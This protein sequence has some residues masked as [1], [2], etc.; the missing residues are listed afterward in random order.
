MPVNLAIALS[1][2]DISSLLLVTLWFITSWYSCQVYTA[3]A[4][5][6]SV[7]T[8]GNATVDKALSPAVKALVPV[9]A[10]D[11][12]VDTLVIALAK[13]PIVLK[14]PTTLN[15]ADKAVAPFPTA[16]TKLP[17]PFVTPPNTSNKAPNLATEVTISGFKLLIISANFPIPSLISSTN[18]NKLSPSL[19]KLFF[20]WVNDCCIL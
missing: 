11:P 10:A 2:K 20:N 6:A 13:L 3:V 14:F 19:V 15:S 9:A 18:G 8:N 12:A 1:I 7:A 16:V 17:T 4:T 5:A